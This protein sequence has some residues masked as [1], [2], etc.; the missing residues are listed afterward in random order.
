MPKPFKEASVNIV[1]EMS[2]RSL[3]PHS[4]DIKKWTPVEAH[5]RLANQSSSAAILVFMRTRVCG[6]ESPAILA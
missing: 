4:M 6:S 1:T 3:R 5:V 2:P